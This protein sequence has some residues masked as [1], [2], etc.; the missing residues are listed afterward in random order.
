MQRDGRRLVCFDLGGVIV[1]TARRWEI[2]CAATGVPYRGDPL[3]DERLESFAH[4]VSAYETDGLSWNE[5]LVQGARALDGLHTRDELARIHEGW[6]LGEYAGVA[7]ILRRLNGL[8]GIECACLSNT[9]RRHWEIMEG[10]PERFAAF[11]LLA[12]RWNSF[13]L[14]LRKPD[15]A[16][17]HA[18]GAESGARPQHILFFDDRAENVEAARACGWKAELIDRDREIARQIRG[19]LT[20]HGLPGF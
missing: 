6:L 19:A 12:R 17:Y 18:V 2:A 5:Y 20:V 8:D 1:E 11:H 13:E 4:A 10:A 14:R 7:E 9:N 15:P 3:A 16:I